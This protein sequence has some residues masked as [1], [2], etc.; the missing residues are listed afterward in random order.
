MEWFSTFFVSAL[1][2]EE[3]KLS[4]E[5]VSATGSAVEASDGKT[6]ASL[7]AN[8]A[9]ADG[10]NFLWRLLDEIMLDG[11]P[12]LFRAGLAFL[13]INEHA[14]RKCATKEEALAVLLPCTHQGKDNSAQA[15][16]SSPLSPSLEERHSFVTANARRRA[17]SL[18][19]F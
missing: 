6:A 17:Q 1:T 19:A 10:R 9:H 2:Q 15:A 7:A 18:D 14:L 4:V 12:V 8:Q 13:A 11:W 3:K 16:P 5:C